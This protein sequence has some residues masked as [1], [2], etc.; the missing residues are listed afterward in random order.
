MLM[1][2]ILGYI[3]GFL[4][5]IGF[6]F[7]MIKCIKLHPEQFELLE[8]EEILKNVKGDYWQKAY[9]QEVQNSGEFAFTNQRIMFRST[10]QWFGGLN[11]EISYKE[12]MSV[13][14]SLV[15]GLLPVAFTVKTANSESYKFAIMKRHIY[16]DLINSIIKKGT[17][18]Q[19]EQN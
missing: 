4:I 5:F 13:E 14:K 19:G 9:G 2:T 6:I 11:I 10:F 3:T 12:I 15:Q 16:I 7:L 8:G 17:Q 1:V 18:N